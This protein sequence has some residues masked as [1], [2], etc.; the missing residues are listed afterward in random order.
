LTHA[1]PERSWR[2]KCLFFNLSPAL[3]KIKRL[4]AVT[5]SIFKIYPPQQEA[6][7]RSLPLNRRVPAL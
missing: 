4:P 2:Q 3:D 1:N 7:M 5:G 6:L